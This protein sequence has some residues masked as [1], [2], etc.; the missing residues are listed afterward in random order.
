MKLSG[1]VIVLVLIALLLSA[2]CTTSSPASVTQS[3]PVPST[4]GGPMATWPVTT[5]AAEPPVPAVTASAPQVTVTV[6]H[7]IIPTKA[8]KDT[9]LHFA[10]EAPQDWVVTTR[11]VSLPEGSQGLMY[12][13][14]L[15]PDDAFSIITY[16][17]N[18][19]QDQAYRDTFRNWRPAPVETTVDINGITF[20]RFET[21]AYGET[22]VGYVA[23]KASANDLGYASVI[24][25]TANSSRMFEQDDFEKVVSSFTYFTK[26]KAVN[27]TG[28]EIPRVR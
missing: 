20:G 24:T 19:N 21:S 18:L 14:E 9:D 6:I 17:V 7:Y 28:T 22:H 3:S 27:V 1:T 10:F 16:P 5:A 11:L 8:W 4:P 26:D 2:G 13:T 12:K 25:Y 23:Q 15:V